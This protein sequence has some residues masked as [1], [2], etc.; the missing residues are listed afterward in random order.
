MIVVKTDWLYIRLGTEKPVP[1]LKAK[2]MPTEPALPLGFIAP[3][4][5]SQTAPR[6]NDVA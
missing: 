2:V 4:P 1:K 3:Q 6:Q 5:Q